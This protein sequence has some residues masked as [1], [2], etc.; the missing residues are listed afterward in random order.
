MDGCASWPII[1]A[2]ARNRRSKSGS[3]PV[4]A[5]ITLTARVRWNA[6][7]RTRHTTPIPPASIR[8]ISSY[9][10]NSGGS[11][12]QPSRASASAPSTSGKLS[13]NCF[14]TRWQSAQ[15]PT[16]SSTALV[17][18]RESSSRRSLSSVS[19]FGHGLRATVGERDMS[20]FL[21]EHLLDTVSRLVHS[22]DAQIQTRGHFG[23]RALFDRGL[24]EG[25]P[26]RLLELCA[27]SFDHLCGGDAGLVLDYSTQFD[28]RIGT[29]QSRRPFQEGGTANGGT[30]RPALL[31]SP[32]INQ[33]VVDNHLQPSTELPL[34]WV[35]AIL[36]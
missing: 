6:S 9:P 31:S 25:L 32:E 8:P 5:F 27:N 16:C 14:S 17:S 13:T 24:V 10:G 11:S 21:E 19:G 34:L 1:R 4:S 36:W 26:G 2:S 29:R 30:L 23:S 22:R 12:S 7:S 33:C 35:V 28:G 18:S 15:T 20:V 3:L